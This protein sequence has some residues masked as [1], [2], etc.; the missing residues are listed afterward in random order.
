MIPTFLKYWEEGYQ[1]VCGVKTSSR[2][3]PIMYKLRTI[4]YKLI[5]KFSEVDQIEH[6]TGF[7]LYDRSFI[8]VLRK[9]NDPTPFIRGSWRNL[10]ESGRKFRMSSPAGGQGRPITTGIPCMTRRCSV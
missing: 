10:A 9:L 5:K 7:G 6:F 3:N 4:Y 8:E 1:I 2:E